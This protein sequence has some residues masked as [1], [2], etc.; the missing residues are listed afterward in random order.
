MAKES[1]LELVEWAA[2]QCIGANPQ[3]EYE[4]RNKFLKEVLFRINLEK[5]PTMQM[6]TCQTHIRTMLQEGTLTEIK[7]GN[8]LRYSIQKSTT[9]QDLI[10]QPMLATLPL[11]SYTTYNNVESLGITLSQNIAQPIAELLNE[12]FNEKNLF[13]N[14]LGDKAIMCYYF[15][16]DNSSSSVT[17]NEYLQRIFGGIKFFKNTTNS[18]EIPILSYEDIYANEV[19]IYIEDEKKWMPKSYIQPIQKKAEKTKR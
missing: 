5:E 1:K 15:L 6:S 4:N 10:T 17:L 18:Q 7:I 14:A 16:P 9:K 11:I 13:F 2:G 8:S 3:N 19:Y 12:R